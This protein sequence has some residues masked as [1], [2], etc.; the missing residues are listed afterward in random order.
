MFMDIAESKDW[1]IFRANTLRNAAGNHANRT[2]RTNSI[3][4]NT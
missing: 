2:S 4:S 3:V 1:K